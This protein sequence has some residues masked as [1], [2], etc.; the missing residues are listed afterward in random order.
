MRTLYLDCGNGA[1]GDMFSAAL[2]ELVDNKDVFLNDLNNA[3]IPG[4]SVYAFPA[5]SY[6]ISGTHFRVLVNG[7]EEQPAELLPEAHLAEETDLRHSHEH[8]HSHSHAHTHEDGREHEHEHSHTH[9]H[10]H[11]HDHHHEHRS[12]ADIT[13]IIESLQVSDR[14]KHDAKEIYY[15]IADAESSVHGTTVSEIHFHEVGTIDAVADVVSAAM[16]VE[17]LNPERILASPVETGSGKIR[18]AHGILPVPAPATAKL[19]QGIP[20]YSSGINGELCTPTGAAIL[21]YF[22]S[23]FGGMPPMDIL[24]VGYGMGSKD[25]G[26]PNFLRAFLGNAAENTGTAETVP[27]AQKPHRHHS[28]SDDEAVRKTV[29]NR[30]ARAIG[31]LESVKRMVDANRSAGDILIQLAAVESSL[32]ST[33]RVIIKEHFGQAIDRAIKDQSEQTMDDLNGLVDKFLK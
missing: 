13:A 8:E 18:C 30:L 6:D 20:V 15:L 23:S 11:G 28:L 2:W 16:L 3:G 9:E 10:E 33:A 14:V 25:F 5:E 27:E 29:S 31:H 4:V 24:D 7:E 17:R 19:L 12:L 22:V 26:R 21:K 1:S 32:G